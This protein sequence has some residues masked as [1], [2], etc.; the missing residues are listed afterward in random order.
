MGKVTKFLSLD[1]QYE[2]AQSCLKK[3][4]IAGAVKHIKA[5]LVKRQN[6]GGWG[7]LGWSMLQKGEYREGLSAAKK[8]RN[9]ALKVPSKPLLA[10]ADCL[11]G[12][13]HHEAG[14]KVLAERYYRESL[15][16]HPRTETCVFL[17]VLLNEQGRSIE[18]KVYFQKAL[19]IDP[20][21]VE[22]RYNMARWYYTHRDYERTVKHL[23]MVLDFNPGYA[24]AVELLTIALWQF[25]ST[26]FQQARELLE[27]S[28]I[29]DITNVRKQLLLALTYRL[30]NKTKDAENTFR[31]II[32]ELEENSAAHLL[33][34]N[35]LAEKAR[36]HTEAESHFRKALEISPEKGAN[37]YYY[38]K[39]LI[40]NDCIEEAQEHLQKAA[41]L[42]YEKAEMLLENFLEAD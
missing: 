26:G 31:F 25:G 20:Q 21:D 28:V 27:T 15:D 36:N 41:Q 37:H 38:A 19:Q 10:I 18:A 24:D 22:A 32:S 5:A 33:F 29:S 2:Q 6:P 4:D 40:N 39:F 42:G 12:R 35:M 14:R 30:L 8:M 17:G 9:T 7:L 23:R 13:I 11:M 34:A 16:A 1:E 3:G